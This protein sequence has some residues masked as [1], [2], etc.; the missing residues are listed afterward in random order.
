MSGRVE[1]ECVV[2]VCGSVCM[3][4]EVEGRCVCT[5]GK[6]N[7]VCVWMGRRRCVNLRSWFS[8]Y[9]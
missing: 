7:E 1:V 2:S 9:S 8:L 4:V 5:W 6:E 3:E